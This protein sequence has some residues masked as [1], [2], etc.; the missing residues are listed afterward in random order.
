MWNALR[1]ARATMAKVDLL[2]VED[3]MRRR[4][5][6]ARKRRDRREGKAPVRIVLPDVP[7]A[8]KG[9][10]REPEQGDGWLEN[11]RK[12]MVDKC[13]KAVRGLHGAHRYEHGSGRNE[14][15]GVGN[16]VQQTSSERCAE[17]QWPEESA[18]TIPRNEECRQE[19]A[20][21]STGSQG[22]RPAR[23]RGAELHHFIRSA[24]DGFPADKMEDLLGAS[25]GDQFHDGIQA[26][27]GGP[28]LKNWE[29]FASEFLQ[30]TRRDY[31]RAVCT[32]V[33]TYSFCVKPGGSSEP[34]SS[35]QG[36]DAFRD[37]F[38]PSKVDSTRCQYKV[39]PNPQ[40]EFGH[41]S[42]ESRR[43][44]LRDRLLVANEKHL[45]LLRKF[46][47]STLCAQQDD[48]HTDDGESGEPSS[49]MELESFVALRSQILSPARRGSLVQLY[50]SLF[51]SMR[52]VQRERG[53][54]AKA[55]LTTLTHPL[56]M[57]YRR[58]TRE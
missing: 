57:E 56:T 21:P 44:A 8:G 42:M 17:V 4:M 39:E 14:G 54:L 11:R 26:R 49:L 12:E 16:A 47:Q 15:G 32:C 23:K 35:R 50:R 1:I 18:D 41:W 29:A 51:S 38:G 24:V 52:Q 45:S 13:S 10:T 27:L 20:G 22:I 28:I 31:E 25:G 30:E 58:P 19:A 9:P 46:H 2:E 55:S 5:Q 53:A 37:I 3:V 43:K 48:N 6:E 33:L 34:T 40:D 36:M 7:R